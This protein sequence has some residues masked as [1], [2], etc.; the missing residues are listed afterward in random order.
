MKWGSRIALGAFL[1]STKIK[2]ARVRVKI[3]LKTR[4]P[5]IA[6]VPHHVTLAVRAEQHR[7]EACLVRNVWL[8]NLKKRQ[9][10]E[11]FVPLV[12]RAIT[13]TRQTWPRASNAHLGMPN[14]CPNKRR[15]FPASKENTTMPKVRRLAS[16]VK[17]THIPRTKTEPP[18]AFHVRKVVLPR[19][20]VHR[21]P[22][23]WPGNLKKRQTPTKR[24]V[25]LVNRALTRTRQT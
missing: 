8:A 22:I 3:A 5:P 7:T 12:H 4:Q 17:Q 24:F 15:A 23:V 16:F 21:A 14:R 11:R 18:N 9:T 20:E 6:N 25:P 19:K 10:T 1:G 13:R 2:K